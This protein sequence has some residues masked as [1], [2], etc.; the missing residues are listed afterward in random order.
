[1]VNSF[2]FLFSKYGQYFLLLNKFVLKIAFP[3]HKLFIAYK[4]LMVD[5]FSLAHDFL[6]LRGLLILVSQHCAFCFG[7]DTMPLLP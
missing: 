1:M 2:L 6:F 5:F 4:V 7:Q 3:S